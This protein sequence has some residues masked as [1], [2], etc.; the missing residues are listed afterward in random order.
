VYRPLGFSLVHWILS[1][2]G[3]NVNDAIIRG[4][5]GTRYLYPR[6]TIIK[7]ILSS[8]DIV[9]VE[10]PWLIPI[11][12]HLKRPSQPLVY[13]SHN[14]ELDH[15]TFTHGSPID[16]FLR[17]RI[18][19]LEQ[20]AVETADL[21][22]CVSSKIAK[23]YKNRFEFE[24]EVSVKPNGSFP[25]PTASE[26]NKQSAGPLVGLFVGTSHLPNVEAVGH[27]CDTASELPLE[28]FE[29]RV[30]GT[31]GEAYS[32]SVPDNVNIVGYVDDIEYYYRTA[33]FALNP[34]IH[35]SGTNIK[36]AEY[37]ASGLPTIS[38]PHGARG[39]NVS[40]DNGVLVVSRPEFPSTIE[41]LEDP[42]L[43]STL[44]LRATETWREE[45]SWRNI[46]DEFFQELHSLVRNICTATN[47]EGSS[48][49]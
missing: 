39:Y 3:W 17:R 15:T 4:V 2:L 20:T 10:E 23:K 40:G 28:R 37:L 29:I 5:Q 47:G 22:V 25:F 44:G 11:V 43:R 26:T 34:V 16:W 8:S 9:V 21:I 48:S 32:G 36:I 35:G 6:R 41:E 19:S 27:I 31:C 46:S 45:Y 33:D 12:K 24:G 18:E 14:Y 49:Q 38:T 30:V 7:D 42:S 13:S 1:S